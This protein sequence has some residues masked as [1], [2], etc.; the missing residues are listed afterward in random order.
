MTYSFGMALNFIA[1]YV[2][3]SRGASRAAGMAASAEQFSSRASS[4][5]SGD[6]VARIDRLTLV[7]EA[8][9]TMLEEDGRTEDDL[10][11]KISELDQMDGNEDGVRIAPPRTCPSCKAK[12]GSTLRICQFCGADVGDPDPFAH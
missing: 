9:W 11:A 7:V 10:I 5:R 12:V 8:M 1:G 6:L 3:G 2:V 4:G